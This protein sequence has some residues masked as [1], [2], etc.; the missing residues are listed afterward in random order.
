MSSTSPLIRQTCKNKIILGDFNTK[1]GEAGIFGGI[2]RKGRFHTTTS[3]NGFRL[4]DFEKG[5]DVVLAISTP[6]HPQRTMKIS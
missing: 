6:K 4:I 2:I 5:H 3:D 1:L